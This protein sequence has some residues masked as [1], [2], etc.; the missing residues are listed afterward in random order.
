LKT[1][2][3]D[4]QP[5]PAQFKEPHAKG[6]ESSVYI[7]PEKGTVTKVNSL[8][9]NFTYSEFLDRI[10]LHN[11][12]FPD[13]AY[14]LTGF[15]KRDGV[16][17]PILEQP[18]IKGEPVTQKEL[19][20]DLNRMGFFQESDGSNIFY[21]DELGVR[22]SDLHGKNVI[23]DEDGK[24]RYIDPVVDRKNP[25]LDEADKQYYD[26]AKKN[27]QAQNPDATTGETINQ[28]TNEKGQGQERQQEKL[29]TEQPGQ[30]DPASLEPDSEVGIYSKR[31]NSWYRKNRDGNLEKVLDLSY[32]PKTKERS[33]AEINELLD[34]INNIDK[35]PSKFNQPVTTQAERNRIKSLPRNTLRG[36]VRGYFIDGGKVKWER[37]NAAVRDLKVGVKEET[38]LRSS[39]FDS[40]FKAKVTDPNAPTIEEVAGK[41][42]QQYDAF[43]ES[44]Y[45]DAIIDLLATEKRG[46]WFFNQRRDEDTDLDTVE[47][48]KL[49]EKDL[50]YQRIEELEAEEFAKDQSTIRLYEAEQFVYGENNR[51][52]QENAGQGNEI[53]SAERLRADQ[54][55]EPGAAARIRENGSEAKSQK[56]LEE[57]KSINLTHVF[58]L[59]MG[60]NQAKGTYLS[61]EEQN[62]Y[63]IQS[64]QPVSA[65]A[66][67]ENPFV[68]DLNTFAQIQR[69]AIQQRFGKDSVDDLTESEA[70]L[71]AEMMSDFFI[72][73]GYD[74]IYFPESEFQEGELIVFDRSKVTFKG[75]EFGVLVAPYYDTTISSLDDAKKLR[76]NENYKKHIEN[77]QS[78]ASQLGLTVKSIDDTIG[79]FQNAEGKKIREISNRVVIEGGDINSAS[80]FAALLGALA[81]EVQEATIAGQYTER[82]ADNHTATEINLRVSDLGR[83]IDLLEKNGI[84]DFSANESDGS[85]SILDFSNGRDETIDQLISNF[86]DDL[87]QNNITYETTT[88]AIESRYIDTATRTQLLEEAEREV[89]ERPGGASLRSLYQKAKERNRQFLGR[90]AGPGVRL[91]DQRL[92]AILSKNNLKANHNKGRKRKIKHRTERNLI[93]EQSE[94]KSQLKFC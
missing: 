33:I 65:K 88:R 34:F 45:R 64:S 19:K 74:S 48:N 71:L 1:D 73:E 3:V 61:T 22:L 43:S 8:T 24:I 60:Q 58:G 75:N 35:Q 18:L 82:N 29:L 66:N 57:L 21:N 9:K 40:F 87:K 93:K 79:G 4:L 44:E 70:D 72:K 23:K 50:I 11:Q 6:E 85:I 15:T 41:L 55:G 28:P 89:G 94:S 51:N 83:A 17:M 12:L 47:Q 56:A 77:I 36:R 54:F 27:L 38:G 81:P 10:N 90:N 14:Q 69:D 5:D 25:L 37:S 46:D 52:T 16:L 49:Y 78:V 42:A 30:V 62:R 80:R 68:A 91:Q 59:G 84:N 67:V 2:H 86:A 26:Q 13:V 76:Q 63:A 32:K 31:A 53:Q 92:N 7:N 20:E 39:D